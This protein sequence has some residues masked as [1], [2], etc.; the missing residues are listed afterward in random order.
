[1]FIN[2]LLMNFFGLSL[3]QDTGM[4]SSDYGRVFNMPNKHIHVSA[5]LTEAD[6]VRQCVDFRVHH[7]DYFD[8]ECFAYNYEFDRFT[9]ELIHSFE[10]MNYQVSYQSRWRT[11]LKLFE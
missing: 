9:C 10:P 6:C 1:M 5:A 8:E 7:H 4:V 3:L 11:G 2:I